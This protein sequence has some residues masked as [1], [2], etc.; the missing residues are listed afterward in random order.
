VALI[1]DAIKDVSSPGSIVL[2]VFGGSGS[3]LIAAHKTG[4]RARLAELHPI[5]CDRIIQRW[6]LYAKDQAVQIACGRNG[7]RQ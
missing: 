7:G 4:R 1:V 6:E 2:D 5:Y 3:T